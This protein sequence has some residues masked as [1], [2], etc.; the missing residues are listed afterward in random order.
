MKKFK[1]LALALCFI[2]VLAPLSAF[3]EE[4]AADEGYDMDPLCLKFETQEDYD[5]LITRKEEC[6]AEIEGGDLKLTAKDLGSTNDLKPPRP[7]NTDQ[8]IRS[9]QKRS[10]PRIIRL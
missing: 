6:S 3:A 1:L 7:E 5:A 2:L 8:P 9:W 4:P 10:A